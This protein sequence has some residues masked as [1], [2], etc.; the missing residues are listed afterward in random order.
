MVVLAIVVVLTTVFL[1][2]LQNVRFIQN[3]LPT[4]LVVP[5]LSRELEKGYRRVAAYDRDYSALVQSKVINVTV[6]GTVS[7]V[8]PWT[9]AISGAE[10]A[11]PLV[12]D[13]R[14]EISKAQV[15]NGVYDPGSGKLRQEAMRLADIAVG[16]TISANIQIDLV[17]GKERVN[18]IFRLPK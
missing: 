3:L 5:G 6:G 10:S 9:V 17:S 2:A 4:R 7:A 13:N 14:L 12:L 1:L 8:A 16:D 11:K 15:F 18:S